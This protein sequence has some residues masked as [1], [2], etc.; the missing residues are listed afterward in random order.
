MP[1]T[2]TICGSMKFIDK[3]EEWQKKLQTEG[4]NVLAPLLVDFHELKDLQDDEMAFGE[5][6]RGETKKHFEKV[7]A[8]GIVLVLNY[9]K[10]E[11]KNYIG[12]NSFFR[13][14]RHIVKN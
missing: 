5:Y 2:I 1:K 6:K 4:Y 11:I 13:K 10:N 8:S 12:G 14:T 7:K 9:D 3:M